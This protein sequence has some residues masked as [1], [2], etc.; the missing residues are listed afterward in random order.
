M[1]NVINFMPSDFH[2]VIKDKDALGDVAHVKISLPE[3][4]LDHQFLFLSWRC[5][6][7]P[8]LELKI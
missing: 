6:V 1:S 3:K 8:E 7:T 2:S 4:Q 5:V